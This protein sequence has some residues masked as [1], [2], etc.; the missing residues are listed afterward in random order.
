MALVGQLASA[1]TYTVTA[2]V[3]APMPAGVPEITSPTDGMTISGDSVNVSG[4][5][6]VITPAIIVAIYRDSTLIGSTECR[7]DGAFFVAV[8]LA[9]GANVLTATVVTI[10]GGI[11]G[12]SAPVTV[13]HPQP[14]I[15]TIGGQS[16]GQLADM[17]LPIHITSPDKFV[18]LGPDGS[19][20]WHG[21][22]S[23]GTPPYAVSIEWGDG[24]TDKH[25]ITDHA[26]R[27]YTHRYGTLH[28]YSITVRVTDAR[29]GT[30]TF[31]TVAVTLA[32]HALQ[33]VKDSGSGQLPP[34]MVFI[35]KYMWQI[36]IVT[37]SGLIFLWYLEHGHHLIGYGSKSKGGRLR[38]H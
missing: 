25:T 7:A 13:T 1:D 21:S 16:V 31:R 20:A 18:L 19:A 9:Y 29:D 5:C 4:T 28:P 2:T 17:A 11:G 22:I 34:L 14:V 38:F 27:L 12:T 37:L 15:P 6:P 3:P 23:G 26:E 33:G 10:T 35:D 36:Y 8:P 30:S 24:E 32:L